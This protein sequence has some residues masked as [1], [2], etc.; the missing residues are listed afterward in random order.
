MKNILL[1]FTILLAMFSFAT[2]NNYDVSDFT[3]KEQEQIIEIDFKEFTITTQEQRDLRMQ[4]KQAIKSRILDLYKELKD[5]KI[6]YA[7]ITTRHQINELKR[8]LWTIN[9]KIAYSYRQQFKKF[10]GLK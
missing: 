4:E 1:G 2:A 7:K 8:E 5:E 3:E 9:T 10:L 6:K